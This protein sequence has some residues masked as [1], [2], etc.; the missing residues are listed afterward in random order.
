MVINNLHPDIQ[1]T[2]ESSHTKLP[3]LHILIKKAHTGT[4]IETD[5]YYK[6]TDSKQYLLFNSCTLSM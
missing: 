5:V 6:L 1:V 3:F 2:S 4:T